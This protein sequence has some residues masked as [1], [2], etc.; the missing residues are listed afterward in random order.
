M[1]Q[2]VQ[3]RRDKNGKITTYVINVPSYED[4]VVVSSGGDEGEDFGDGGSGDT[5]GGGAG[6]WI[7]GSSS[8]GNDDIIG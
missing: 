6:I 2:L 8:I 3:K 5:G 7:I 4:V 1:R